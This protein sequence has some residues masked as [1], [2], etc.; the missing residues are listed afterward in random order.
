[1]LD[2]LSTGSIGLTSGTNLFAGTLPDAPDTAAVVYETGGFF[3]IHA[4][5]RADCVIE[6]PRIQVVTRAVQYRTARQ[7]AHNVFTLLDGTRGRTINSVVY[8]WIS[9]VS[10]P[11]DMNQ[12]GSGRAR[13]VMNFDIQKDLHTS[14]ST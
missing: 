11:A 14:T 5:A 1:M 4:N 12:D 2:Y 6:R 10:S 13:V 7:L 8:H 9:G 3:P